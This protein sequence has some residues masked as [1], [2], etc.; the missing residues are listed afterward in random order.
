MGDMFGHAAKVV[1]LISKS[2]VW[3]CIKC[4]FLLNSRRHINVH[5]KNS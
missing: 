1:Q 4:L 2:Y 3:I 5:E